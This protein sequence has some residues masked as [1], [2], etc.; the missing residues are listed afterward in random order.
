MLQGRRAIGVDPNTDA[1][2]S[3]NSRRDRRSNMCV[4]GEGLVD[5]LIVARVTAMTVGSMTGPAA[6][7]PHPVIDTHERPSV[8]AVF[9]CQGEH[10]E[11]PLSGLS[12]GWPKLATAQ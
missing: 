5:M 9:Q 12:L 8:A 3:E 1:S 2:V 7:I 6:G 4:P 11:N 10:E